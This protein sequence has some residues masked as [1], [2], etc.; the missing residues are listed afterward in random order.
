MIYTYLPKDMLEH[1][2]QTLHVKAY[3]KVKTFS[4]FL[5]MYFTIYFIFY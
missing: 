2:E 3:D 4:S 1:D 5:K